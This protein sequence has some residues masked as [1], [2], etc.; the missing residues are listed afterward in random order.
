MTDPAL[1]Y[2]CAFDTGEA[3][4]SK[5]SDPANIQKGAFLKKDTMQ[6]KRLGDKTDFSD[7]VQALLEVWIGTSE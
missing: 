6:Q 3:I 4:T 1:F 7:L 5:R 2:R